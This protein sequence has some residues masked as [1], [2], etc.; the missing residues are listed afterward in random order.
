M[1][2]LRFRVELIRSRAARIFAILLFSSLASE[3]V[4]E[5]HVAMASVASGRRCEML[6]ETSNV[7]TSRS[8]RDLWRV[9]PGSYFMSLRSNPRHYWALA[10]QDAARFLSRENLREGSVTGDPHL[11]NFGDSRVAGERRFMLVDLDDGG[12]APLALDFGRLALMSSVGPAR[13]AR[14]D[15]IEAYVD[16]LRGDKWEKPEVLRE[17]LEVGRSED[18]QR[19]ENYIDRVA[20]RSADGR[21]RF[22]RSG[23][24]FL[25]PG[26]ISRELN[27][28][29]MALKP[30]LEAA[31]PP[32][33]TVD[34]A[35]RVKDSGGSMGQPRFW[36]LRERRESGRWTGEFQAFE[37]KSMGEPA[38][39]AWGPQASYLARMNAMVADY[40][41]GL[42]DENYRLVRVDGHAFWLRE[43]VRDGLDFKD[44]TGLTRDQIDERRE[45]QLYIA[46]WLGRR[47]REI[48]TNWAERMDDRSQ[49]ERFVREISAWIGH[50]VT[51]TQATYAAQTA[52]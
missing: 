11:L 32:G 49:R 2:K 3:L 17:A 52:R 35:I 48:A 16:G 9:V 22:D 15:L 14:A 5:D 26:R 1:G 45:M 47:H 51:E 24:R 28:L 34:T 21:R 12:R 46:N 7:D 23:D 13:V 4:S 37:F 41:H 39:S 50:V 29:W 30:G 31:L 19:N 6:F 43:R 8:L 36:F 20:P 40:R 27:E 33:R 44:E 18:Q 38:T 25:E 10:R 42:S